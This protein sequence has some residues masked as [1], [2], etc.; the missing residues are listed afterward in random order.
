[1]AQVG[2]NLELSIV[3]NAADKLTINGWYTR[4]AN[5]IE[6]FRLSD[7]G[8]VLASQVDSLIAAMRRPAPIRPWRRGRR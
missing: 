2:N 1:M 7:G 4:S 6:E 8:V 3:G 5:Q